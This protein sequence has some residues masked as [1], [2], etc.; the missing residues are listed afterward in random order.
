M[1]PKIQQIT[2]VIVNSIQNW[3]KDQK[4][5]INPYPE[6]DFLHLIYKKNQIDTIQWHIEDEIRRP[7]LPAIELVK[8]KREIDKLNQ[9]RTDTVELLDDRLFQIFKDIKRQDNARMNSETPAWLL[10]RMS[11]LEL[12]IYHM[13]EQVNRK[14]A[15]LSHINK[16][17]EKLEILLD[18]RKDLQ[19]CFED[20][21]DDLYNGKKYMKV[22]RQMKMYN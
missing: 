9:D 12:K 1:I 11:I 13:D 6:S 20:L 4:P 15:D 7:E 19:Q 10:D 8:F 14:D 16:C 17:K 22:Y 5:T 3:H 21:T 18:Q 2:E